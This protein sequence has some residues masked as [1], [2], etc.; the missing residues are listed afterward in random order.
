MGTGFK[1]KS[2]E[3]V[4]K[5]LKMVILMKVIFRTINFRDKEYLN[6]LME[7]FILDNFWMTKLMDK[8]KWFFQ[9]V[10][11]KK[12]FG[13]MGFSIVVFKKIDNKSKQ[14]KKN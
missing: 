14:F 7:T 5:Y 12:A 13:Q 10:R 1:I 11:Y 8:A 2:M 3:M 9:M 4:L 6:L